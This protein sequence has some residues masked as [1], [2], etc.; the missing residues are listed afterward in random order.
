[1]SPELKK[2]SHFHEG[3]ISLAVEV[4]LAADRFIAL[5]LTVNPSLSFGLGLALVELEEEG[6]ADWLKTRGLLL[7]ADPRAKPSL[8]ALLEK[9]SP[10]GP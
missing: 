3:E 4:Q 9:E 2:I 10:Q 1:M 7:L 8:V 5:M 6:A